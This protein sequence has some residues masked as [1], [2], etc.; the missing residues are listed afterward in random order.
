MICHKIQTNQPKHEYWYAIIISLLFHSLLF[1]HQRWHELYWP[2]FK[3]HSRS[4]VLFSSQPNWINKYTR[5]FTTRDKCLLRQQS[6][7]DHKYRHWFKKIYLMAHK[8]KWRFCIRFYYQI[9]PSTSYFC[10]LVDIIS[11]FC[12]KM[13]P[14][15]CVCDVWTYDKK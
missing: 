3:Y 2:S 14:N 1:S 5:R 6:M 15:S 11:A 4:S 8:K 9:F 13:P 10:E 12:W 7:V